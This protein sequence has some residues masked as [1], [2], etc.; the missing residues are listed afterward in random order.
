MFSRPYETDEQLDFDREWYR[1][2]NK[3][4][5]TKSLILPLVS[6]SAMDRLFTGPITPMAETLLGKGS[7][8]NIDLATRGFDALDRAEIAF[9]TALFGKD[10]Q[11]SVGGKAGNGAVMGVFAT[12]HQKMVLVD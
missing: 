10:R 7:F 2:A 12:H 9:R 1:R 11:R 8:K 4:N 5:V 6:K 3:N